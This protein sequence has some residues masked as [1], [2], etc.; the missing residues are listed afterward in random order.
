[1]LQNRFPQNLAFGYNLHTQN[2]IHKAPAMKPHI[3]FLL[4]TTLLAFAPTSRAEPAKPPAG[5]ALESQ[6]R[7]LQKSDSL[8]LYSITPLSGEENGADKFHGYPIVGQCEV[9]GARK[10]QLIDTFFNSI[11]RRNRHGKVGATR[12]FIPHHALRA[13]FEK[14]NIDILICFQCHKAYFFENQ[15]KRAEIVSAVPRELFNQIL[16]DAGATVTD[17]GH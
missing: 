6:K 16:T 10:Q 11:T 4:V 8:I 17:R 15:N 1:V 12:C 3:Q 13:V 7:V 14:R 2:D 9:S 5:D